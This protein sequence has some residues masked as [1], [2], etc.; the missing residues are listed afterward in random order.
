MAHHRQEALIIHRVLTLGNRTSICLRRCKNRQGFHHENEHEA[1]DNVHDTLLIRG[2]AST[3]ETEA[4]PEI[5]G[6]RLQGEGLTTL[7]RVCEWAKTIDKLFM[8]LPHY[9]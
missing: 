6:C 7:S 1:K 2:R 4:A 9:K 5:A 8:K 3:K